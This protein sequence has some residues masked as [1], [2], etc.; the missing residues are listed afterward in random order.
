MI[1]VDNSAKKRVFCNSDKKEV[2]DLKQKV[3]EKIEE[4][5]KTTKNYNE[6]TVFERELYIDTI[7]V[8]KFKKLIDK[9]I[10]NLLRSKLS[11]DFKEELRTL[12]NDL[13][14]ILVADINTIKNYLKTK[15]ALNS[16]LIHQGDKKL[17]SSDFKK[18]QKKFETLYSENLSNIKSS[19]K[20]PFFDLFE[21]INVCPYCNRNFIN[22]IYKEHSL[23]GDNKNQSPDIE[24]F[25]PKS[26]YPFLS[27]SISNL[28]P[29]C[30]FCNKIK[31]DVDTYKY[32]CL[33]PYEIKKNDFRFDFKF[34]SNQVKEVKLMSKEPRCKNSGIL[35]LE[36]LYNEV[37]NKQINE[38]FDDIL[39]Y[40]KSYKRSLGKFKLTE[41]DYKKIFRNYYDEKDF[42]KHPLS[43]MTK[44][45]YNQI[46]GLI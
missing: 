23:S 19:F 39:K 45:L 4:I 46:N 11:D 6:L 34:K 35:N 38:I 16:L 24:H 44:D 37:H 1:K 26:I 12:K 29:S 43:K 13:Y 32:N 42:N 40:P 2:L 21:D 14:F 3:I 18:Y 15:I 31:S 17:K 7:S 36:S 22:P 28:L 9:Q 10:T 30:S 33:S 41:S 5:E 20:R 8:F 27:L 25:Y